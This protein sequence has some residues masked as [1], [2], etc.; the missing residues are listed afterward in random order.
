MTFISTI[1]IV[2]SFLQMFVVYFFG[3]YSVRH[4][5]A[6]ILRIAYVFALFAFLFVMLSNSS[7]GYVMFTIYRVINLFFGAA[8]AVS[9]TSLIFSIVPPGERTSAIAF[10][11]IITGLVGFS[12]TLITSPIM[13]KLQGANL[14][15]FGT[16][17]Y[18]QQILAFVSFSIT[19]LLLIYYQVFCHRL[20]KD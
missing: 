7:N 17:L 18:A 20:I 11:T 16:A 8:S 6:S 4:S 13:E 15:L 10:N 1:G 3:R 9:S 2:I 5:Y 12:V 14:Q 19:V